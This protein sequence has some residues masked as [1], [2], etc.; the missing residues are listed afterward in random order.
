[1]GGGGV[2]GSGELNKELDENNNIGLNNLSG[3]S[4]VSNNH[5]DHNIEITDTFITYSKKQ[6]KKRDLIVSTF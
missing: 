1:M 4:C 2:V 6:I 5:C 3:M